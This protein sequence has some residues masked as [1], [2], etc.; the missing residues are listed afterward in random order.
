[1]SLA[2]VV[3]AVRKGS[4][5]GVPQWGIDTSSEITP[6]RVTAQKWADLENAR[7]RFRGESF[8]PAEESELERARRRAIIG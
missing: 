2:K 1:M 3:R 6:S 4:Y 7:A 8:E 5:Q